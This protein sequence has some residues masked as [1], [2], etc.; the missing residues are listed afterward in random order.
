MRLAAKLILVLI[1][2]VVLTLVIDGLASLQREV[3]FF[4]EDMERDARLLGRVLSR[5]VDEAWRDGGRERAEALVREANIAEH[6]IRARLLDGASEAERAFTEPGPRGRFVLTLPLTGRRDASLELSEPL[7]QLERYREQSVMKILVLTARLIGLGAVLVIGLG[8]WMVGR[9]L[10]RIMAKL[11]RMS[12]G[13][14]S[15]PVAL[16]SRDE[17]GELGRALNALCEH[18][19]A[20]RRAVAEE[21]ERR[22]EALEQLRHADRLTTVGRLSAGIAH[23]LGTPLNIVSGRAELIAAGAITAEERARSAEVIK[24]QAE[25]M[26]GIIRQLLDFARSHQANRAPTELAGLARKTVALLEPLG[27]ERGVA[28][29]FRGEEG[30]PL[31]IDAGQVQHALSNIIMNAVQAS[32]GK[33]RVA[34]ELE[35]SASGEAALRVRDDGPGIAADQLEHV[36]DPF[37]TTKDIGEGTGLGLSIAHGIARDHGGRIE[38]DSAPGRGSCFTIVLPGSAP[39]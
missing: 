17:L 4:E 37:F 2:G 13:D 36:F 15:G 12:A 29:S 6:P 22:I 5:L 21:S 31:D 34:V 39:G 18:F 3:D 24:E 23:E 27:R 19:E 35:R 26:T 33:G 32:D 16:R 14:L 10:Q 8:T 9:P 28:L 38:V 25:L 30:A 1:L 7:T 11:R 20:A